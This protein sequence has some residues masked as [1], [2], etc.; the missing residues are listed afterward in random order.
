MN[1]LIYA[2]ILRKQIE[3]KTTYRCVPL[4][5]IV[6]TR[7]S[8]IPNITILYYELQWY[9]NTTQWS[10]Q[11]KKIRIFLKYVHVSVIRLIED[12]TCIVSYVMIYKE[13]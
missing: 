6:H 4:C 10:S 1:F 12:N 11:F 9:Y 8:K 3:N 5:T 13:L 2:R 7:Y